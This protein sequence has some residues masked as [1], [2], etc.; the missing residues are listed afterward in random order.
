MKILTPMQFQ[1]ILI[2]VVFI[3]ICS[4]SIFYLNKKNEVNLLNA[5][6]I[7]SYFSEKSKLGMQLTQLEIGNVSFPTGNVIIRDPLTEFDETQMPF[8][9]TVPI[10]EYPV[11]LSIVKET[12]FNSERVAAVKITINQN[13]AVRLEEAKV[14][15]DPSKGNSSYELFGGFAVEAGL[16]TVADVK[17]R[18]AYLQ[19]QNKWE[20][21]NQDINIYSG[22]FQDLF[23][24]NAQQHKATFN[25]WINW[26][27]PGT[28]L[29]MPIFP[30]GYGDGAYPVYFAFD[31]NDQVSAI[32]IHFIDLDSEFDED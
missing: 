12:N 7:E 24:A 22:Y 14:L 16:A 8:Y 9:Q 28:N 29:H 6:D 26:I 30:T 18:D 1:L 11:S 17:T 23:E 21:D 5:I 31:S 2:L 15:T 20:L 10:G 4:V 13:K 27:V 19:F 32:Y 3:L 25:D